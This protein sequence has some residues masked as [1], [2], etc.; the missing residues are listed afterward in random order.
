MALFTDKEPIWDQVDRFFKE[1]RTRRQV[2]GGT[3][4]TMGAVI[5]A[6]CGGNGGTK[7]STAVA[8]DSP[9]GSETTS[10]AA[11]HPDSTKISIVSPKLRG[12]S[13]RTDIQACIENGGSNPRCTDEALEKIQ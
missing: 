4:L 2:L 12:R 8:G 5:M 9:T 3:A 11:G 10:E 1:P 13:V 7:D 6:S